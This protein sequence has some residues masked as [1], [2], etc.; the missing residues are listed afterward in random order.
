MSSLC[1]QTSYFPFL[2]E[3]AVSLK[4]LIPTYEAIE[5][6]IFGVER[7]SFAMMLQ[8]IIFNVV[9]EGLRGRTIACLSRLLALLKKH[10]K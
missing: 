3:I 5:V 10:S 2:Y 1:I 4:D 9:V 7:F 6:W 8:N